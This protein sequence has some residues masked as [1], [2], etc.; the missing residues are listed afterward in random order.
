MGNKNIIITYITIRRIIGILGILLPAICLSGGY[1]VTHITPRPSISDYYYS[2]MQDVFVGI[3]FAVSLF[4]ISYKGYERIDDI[5]T[6]VIGLSGFCIAIFPCTKVSNPDALVG[7]FQ[8]HSTCSD[9]IHFIAAALF[10]LLLSVNSVFLFTM[11]DPEKNRDKR[12]KFFRNI[13]YITT[14]ST[15][16]ICLVVL[17]ILFITMGAYR[18]NQTMYLFL[19]ETIMLLAFGVSWIVKGETIL[20]DREIV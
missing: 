3:L 10:F 5:I 17:L 14:G 18:L 7:I 2:N 12:N 16:F 15:I 13:I 9:T 8:L 19:I 4:L 6:T 1:L 11:S 20:R